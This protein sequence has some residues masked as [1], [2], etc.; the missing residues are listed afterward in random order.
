MQEEVRQAFQSHHRIRR[1]SVLSVSPSAWIRIFQRWFLLPV[2]LLLSPC[3]Y[4]VGVYDEVTL[5]GA[6]SSRALFSLVTHRPLLI[7]PFLLSPLWLRKFS[8][9]AGMYFLEGRVGAG[10]RGETVTCSLLQ[11]EPHRKVSQRYQ[12]CS[13]K[14]LF[15]FLSTQALR[16]LS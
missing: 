6:S 8:L 10:G 1:S 9:W 5:W 2:L 13:C 7:T 3:A 16:F 12:L 15:Q 11:S 4:I 14:V